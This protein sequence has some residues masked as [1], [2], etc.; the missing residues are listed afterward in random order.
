MRA[1]F[2]LAML[3]VF[4]MANVASAD[5]IWVNELHYDN[6][7]GDVDEFIEIGIRTP[8]GS[9]ATASDYVIE[10]YN[11]SNGEE[12][13]TTV[14]LDNADTIS[15]PISVINGGATEAVTLYSLLVSG[16]Q[17]GAPDGFAIVDATAGTVVDNLLYSYEGVFTATNGTASGLSSVALSADEGTGLPAG[18]S[19]GAIGTGFGANQ[20]GPSSFAALAATP[21][22]ANAGQVFARPVVIPEPSSIALLGLVGIAGVIR[23]RK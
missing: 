23:R 3:A 18:G 1:N 2:W 9:G 4:A 20:F 16:I 10:F 12:Y 17:N 21:G 19:V 22:S 13:F 11:G 8:N 5:H 14:S 15:A 6:V 7:G